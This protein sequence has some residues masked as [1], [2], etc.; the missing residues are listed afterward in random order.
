MMA[1]AKLEQGIALHRKLQ[2]VNLR[3][4]LSAMTCSRAPTAH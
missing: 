3:L 1:K 4:W 2:Q